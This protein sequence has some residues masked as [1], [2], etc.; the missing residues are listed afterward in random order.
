VTHLVVINSNL[1]A[2]LPRFRDIGGFLLKTATPFLFH[3]KFSDFYLGI[4]RRT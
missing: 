3:A 2:I 1:C 4:D